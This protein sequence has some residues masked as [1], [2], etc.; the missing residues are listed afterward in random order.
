MATIFPPVDHH[1]APRPKRRRAVRGI[2][3]RMIIPNAVTLLALCS[4]LT[5]IRMTIEGRWEIAVYAIL[6][7]AVLDG[8][9]GRIARYLRSTSRFGAE[10]DS[11]ADFLCFGAAPAILLYGWILHGVKSFGW[12]A[13][14]VLAIAMALRLA[15]FNA[16]LDVEKPAWQAN[17]FTGVPAPAG[18]L[19]VLLPVYISFVGVEFAPWAAPIVIAYV[20]LIAFLTVSRIPT[21]SG[22]K[23]ARI[24]REWVLPVLVALVVLVSLIVSFPFEMLTA[25]VIAYLACIPFGWRHW[26]RLAR[27]HGAREDE[28]G[29]DGD[30]QVV[31]PADADDLG[32]ET[33]RDPRSRSS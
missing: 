8:L 7:A 28:V 11:L 15:R 25:I 21:F 30:G 17:F 19:A 6:V 4:G 5:S 13:A 3:V 29:F 22:K 33:G 10:L 26:N 9:D 32:G 14:L 2:P 16:M 24:R 27:E 23:M 1:E 20:F 12:L 18:A 31:L